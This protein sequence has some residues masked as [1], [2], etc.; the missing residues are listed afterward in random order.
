M[1]WVG[2]RASKGFKFSLPFIPSGSPHVGVGF[3]HVIAT[4]C[5]C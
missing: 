1:S 5:M 3:G 2:L 4:E